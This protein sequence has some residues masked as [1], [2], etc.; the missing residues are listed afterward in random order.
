[1]KALNALTIG[2]MIALGG[3]ATGGDYTSI[4]PSQEDIVR[5]QTL[6]TT[7]AINEAETYIARSREKDLDFLTPQ[8]YTLANKAID[9]AKAMLE[10]NQPREN[11]VQKVAVA[12]A[13]LKNS[14]RV[15]IKI[16]NS[17]ADELSIKSSLDELNAP[18]IYKSEYGSLVARLNEIIRQVEEG[19]K[20]DSIGE[21]KALIHEMSRLEAK[22][23][24]YNAL[25]EPKEILK[26]VKYRG[27]P[28]LAPLTYSE[29]L[30]VYSKAEDFISK[31][32]QMREAV[33]QLAHEALFAAKRAL[34][35][36]Q[37]VA[38]LS[39]K[40]G[41]SMEQVVLDEEYRLFRV[42]KALT[43]TDV[44]DNPLEVQSELMA[45]TLSEIV[46]QNQKQED[47][48]IALRDTLIKVRDASTPAALNSK[49]KKLKK[50]KNEWLAKNALYSAKVSQLEAELNAKDTELALLGQQ[51]DSAMRDLTRSEDKNQQLHLASQPAA[52]AN[53]NAEPELQTADDTEVSIETGTAQQ[54]E[55][56]PV[57][58][59]KPP[60]AT[61]EAAQIETV[62]EKAPEPVVEKTIEPAAQTARKAPSSSV[63]DKST[64]SIIADLLAEPEETTVAIAAPVSTENK[65]ESK[66]A[67]QQELKPEEAFAGN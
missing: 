47:L 60:V 63:V 11:I 32:P 9:E 46:A 10:G 7:T 23:I 61:V 44:R 14:E 17:L 43:N 57:L 67:K 18:T 4:K 27:G 40:V 48:V 8:H 41:M 55:T 2:I 13:V 45:Q 21:R 22:S 53:K 49:I 52:E 29:A 35:I 25:N 12:E 39:A 54:Q 59:T 36:T 33:E 26:R 16:K 5:L 50:E 66:P 65:P 6:P 42:A 31:N 28:E 20:A 24:K 64:A 19:K 15:A 30:E 58:E 37:E 38:A 34:Y 62:T 51:L 56:I 1:M 3:C